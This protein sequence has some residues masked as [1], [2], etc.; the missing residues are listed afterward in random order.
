ML[1]NNQPQ[2]PTVLGI[3]LFPDKMFV[4]IIIYHTATNA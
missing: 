3:S 4:D 2:L 1:K